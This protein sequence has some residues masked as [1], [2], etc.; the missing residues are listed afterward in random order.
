MSESTLDALANIDER[1]TKLSANTLAATDRLGERLE[2]LESRPEVGLD[3][4]EGR[5]GNLEKED[6]QSTEVKDRL[7][8]EITA[9]GYAIN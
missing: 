7:G 3:V 1:L 5:I 2:A 4:I 9:I 8:Q 6:A